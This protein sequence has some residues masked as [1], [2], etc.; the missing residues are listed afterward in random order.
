MVSTGKT[1]LV[2]GALHVLP[3]S[4]FSL[5]PL[6]NP[7]QANKVKGVELEHPP[8][9]KGAKRRKVKLPRQRSSLGT[10]RKTNLSHFRAQTT[11]NS[12]V[13]RLLHNERRQIADGPAGQ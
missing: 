3:P 4:A 2:N 13:P 10:P 9:K 5:P 6:H 1:R 11:S 7:L 8:K 12:R